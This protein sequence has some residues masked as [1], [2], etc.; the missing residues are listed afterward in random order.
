LT[1]AVGTD[2][3][4]GLSTCPNDTFLFHGLL[5]GLV[6]RRGL[7]LEFTLADVQELNEALGVG[8]LDVAKASFAAALDLADRFGVLRVG[9]ALGFGVGPVLV[10]RAGLEGPPRSILCPGEGTTATLLLRCLHPELPQ[11]TQVRFDRIL[12]AL[13]RGEADAGVAIHEGRFT[14]QR[15]GLVL[16]EDLGARWEQVS[17]GPVPLGGLL[18]RLD[19]GPSV[20][21][22]LVEVLSESLRWARARPA[23]TLPTM[24]RH[25][26][27]LDDE[28]I[29]QHIELYVNEHTAD[30]GATG[31]QA[32]DELARRSGREG[33]LAI[34][35]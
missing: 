35:G 34:L 18:A 8:R 5:E 27:E 9:S 17:G 25:A 19:L 6:D 21:R 11:P 13:V 3:R 12:P 7:R 4:V 2:L 26:Q 15:M 32:L 16:L 1:G 23:E 20:H 31:R 33:H 14:Y 29:W 24:R 28:A 22:V 10:A 30:L